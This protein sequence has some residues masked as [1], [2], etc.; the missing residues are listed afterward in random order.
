MCGVN[1]A[2]VPDRQFQNIGR[3]VND[4]CSECHGARLHGDMAHILAVTRKRREEATKI[5]L[6]RE[7]Q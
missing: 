2:T 5:G 3:G 7:A 1:E 4:V 6:P